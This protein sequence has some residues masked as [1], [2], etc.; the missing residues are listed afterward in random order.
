MMMSIKPGIIAFMD[1][2][3]GVNVN[4]GWWSL[5]MKEPAC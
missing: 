1:S 4:W 3:P 2:Q 5:L